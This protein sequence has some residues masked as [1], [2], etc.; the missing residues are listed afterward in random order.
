MAA[1]DDVAFSDLRSVVNLLW[2]LHLG[3]RSEVLAALGVAN[4]QAR[5]EL[6]DVLGRLRALGATPAKA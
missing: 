2:R 4:P 6:Q 3:Q 5:L 1:D